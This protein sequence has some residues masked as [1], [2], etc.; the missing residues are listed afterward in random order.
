ME[1]FWQSITIEEVRQ[2]IISQNFPKSVKKPEQQTLQTASNLVAASPTASTIRGRS[3][4]SGSSSSFPLL[5]NTVKELTQTLVNYTTAPNSAVDNLEARLLHVKLFL[6]DAH[7][8]EALMLLESDKI[9]SL[10]QSL[11]SSSHESSPRLLKLVADACVIF[12]AYSHPLLF[13][14]SLF[15]IALHSNELPFSQLF[16]SSSKAN[17][18]RLHRRHH[19]RSLS[20]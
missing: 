12:G 7:I 15:K 6:L 2:H 18:S 19:R 1:S 16:S 17:W 11:V 13:R 14:F 9:L 4:I 5:P 3:G 20:T 8:T 10:A